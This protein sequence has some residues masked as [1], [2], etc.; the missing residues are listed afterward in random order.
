MAFIANGIRKSLST[1]RLNEWSTHCALN[2]MPV[3]NAFRPLSQT[4]RDSGSKLRREKPRRLILES[5]NY[6]KAL[7]VQP[8]L[9]QDFSTITVILYSDFPSIV[10]QFCAKE[11][12]SGQL[13]KTPL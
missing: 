11:F 12:M 8:N 13:Q 3:F 6:Y 1:K 7:I 10:L 5:T 9:E 4:L 2:G